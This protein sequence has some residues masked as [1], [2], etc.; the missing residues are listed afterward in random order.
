LGKY[1]CRAA[2]TEGR[3]ATRTS[4]RSGQVSRLAALQQYH[5]DQH[6]AVHYEKR[7][8]HPGKPAVIAKPPARNN[9][10]KPNQNR[11]RPFHP[12]WH[13]FSTSKFFKILTFAGLLA[14]HDRRK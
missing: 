12:T 2:R 14:V 6:E 13:C 5:D 3:L 8:Q 4:E 1:G 9:N 11:N 10:S 7:G